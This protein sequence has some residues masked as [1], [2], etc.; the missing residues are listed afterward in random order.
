M[1]VG[2]LLQRTICFTELQRSLGRVTHRVLLVQLRDLEYTGRVERTTYAAVPQRVEYAR[3]PLGCM[4]ASLSASAFVD[5]C[6]PMTRT[7][8]RSHPRTAQPLRNLRHACAAHE[9][10]PQPHAP[11]AAIVW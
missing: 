6:V 10:L 3:T 5:R 9:P 1:I 7:P 8:V 2:L 4:H 11:S